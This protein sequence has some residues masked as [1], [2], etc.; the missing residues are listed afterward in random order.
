MPEMVRQ[1]QRNYYIAKLSWRRLSYIALILA[2]LIRSAT[3]IR[4]PDLISDKLWQLTSVKNLANGKGISITKANAH[5]LATFQDIPLADWPPGFALFVIGFYKAGI[6]LL[7]ASLIVEVLLGVLPF[8]FAWIYMCRHLQAYLHPAFP[9]LI[10]MYWAFA[11]MPFES[12]FTGDLIGLSL[13]TLALAMLLHATTLQQSKPATGAYLFSILLGIVSFLLPSFKFL[14]YPMALV[15]PGLWVV[16]ALSRKPIRLRLPLIAV[17]TSTVLITAQLLYQHYIANAINYLDVDHPGEYSSLFYNHLLKFDNI[18]A[19]AFIDPFLIQRFVGTPI[20][21]L[22]ELIITLLVAG[23]LFCLLI[24]KRSTI[25]RWKWFTNR[26]SFFALCS[27]L[28]GLVNILPLVGLSLRYPQQITEWTYDGLWTYV[29][30]IRYYGFTLS[31][32]VFWVF[33][34]AFGNNRL[35]SFVKASARTLLAASFVFSLV[36]WTYAA[37][38]YPVHHTFANRM[39]YLE[40]NPAHVEL[41]KELVNSPAEPVV[42]YTPH[43]NNSFGLLFYIEGAAV[44]AKDSLKEPLYASSP[45]T[46]LVEVPMA[47]TPQARHLTEFCSRNSSVVVAR[48]HDLRSEIHQIRLR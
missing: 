17:A 41:V 46:L 33:F 2:I 23:I 10:L 4:M 16:W 35:P 13:C 31:L 43:Q 36:P 5:D 26:L 32:I 11:Y 48:L 15:F 45:V 18:L 25:L 27:V 30:E 47:D 39:R 1:A 3:E 38:K 6:S 40:I 44:L 20:A 7:S 14:Y 22:A 29:Q 8:M 21:N 42:F 28:L 34:I 37:Y 24:Y 19:K 9:S 12:F